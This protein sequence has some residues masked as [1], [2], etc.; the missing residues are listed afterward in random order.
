MHCW[1]YL[2]N[3]FDLGDSFDDGNIQAV[4]PDVV[5]GANHIWC[6]IVVD[7]YHGLV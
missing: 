3:S 1:H 7:D 6:T 4:D 5:D 2:R